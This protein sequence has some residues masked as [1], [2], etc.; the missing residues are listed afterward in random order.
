MYFFGFSRY[1]NWVVVRT[2]PDK[3]ARRGELCHGTYQSALIPCDTL[4]LVRIGIRVALDLTRLTSEKAM[5]VWAGLVAL[6]LLQVVALRASRLDNDKKLVLE[7]SVCTRAK[8]L[9][10]VRQVFYLEKVGT[11]LGVACEEP[12]VLTVTVNGGAGT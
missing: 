10:R 4:L 12:L 3:V 5:E 8:S 1:S 7:N 9:D 6:A 11:L 2:K